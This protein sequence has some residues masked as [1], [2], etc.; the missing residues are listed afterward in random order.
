MPDGGEIVPLDRAGLEAEVDSLLREG[1]SAVAV[2]FLHAY[3]NPKHEW[4]A[5]DAIRRRHPDLPVT[6]VLDRVRVARIR[7]D[8]DLRDQR[9]RAAPRS[10]PPWTPCGAAH[11]CGDGSADRRDAVER[12]GDDA[13]ARGRPPR[14]DIVVGA[15]RRCGGGAAS[16]D[17]WD[18]PMRSARTSAGPRSTWRS[19][20]TVGS[21]SGPSGDRGPAGP[22]ADRGCDL[23]R[24]R[25]RVRRLDRR[26][27][28]S[29][30]GPRSA[31]ARPGPACSVR[32]RRANGHRLPPRP[33]T[34]RPGSLPRL[35][36]GAGRRGRGPRDQ[37][38]CGRPAWVSTSRTRR[39]GS[40]GSRRRPWP[41][42]SIR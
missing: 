31:G 21:M 35:A 11:R 13:R 12:R 17:G 15:G 20:R 3:A 33:R 39:T 23:D 34:P 7:T 1:S 5:A 2:C 37:R 16:P 24:C 41:T 22:R 9:I 30:C 8:L 14:P 19:S 6:V 18:T 25:R 42:R 36:D 10:S 28:R 32:R 29:A 4:E 38:A 27:G 26:A 40:S